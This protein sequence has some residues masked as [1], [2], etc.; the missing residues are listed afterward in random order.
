MTELVTGGVA[1]LLVALALWTVLASGAFIAATGFVAYGLLQAL[2]WVRL[3]SIDVALTEAAIGGGLIGAL[4]IGA[5]SRLRDTEALA[6]ARAAS[7]RLRALAM[8]V[9]VAVAGALVLCVLALPDLP[10]TLAPLVAASAP[11]TGVGNPVTAVL[12]SFRAL[13]T[14]LE[15]IVLVLALLG[16]WS[17]APD[18]AWGGRPGARRSLQPEGILAYFARLLPPIGLV[19]GVYIFWTGADHP[20]GKFQGA[21]ILAAMW[22]LVLMAGLADAPATGARA[23]RAG[24]ALGPLVFIAVGAAGAVWAGAFLAY[25]EGWAKP[26]IVFI[27]AA[28][29]PTLV[30]VLGL[31]L[32]GAPRRRAQR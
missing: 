12:L 15:A 22:I 20:G 30:L 7:P 8:L 31:V 11:S 4:L 1:L 19:V 28:L 27:E 23:L 29:M 24:V 5:A 17:L 14:L 10:P 3:G 21:A 32:A 18:A 16:V 13:D 9:S 6:D 25:P 2:L 26:M